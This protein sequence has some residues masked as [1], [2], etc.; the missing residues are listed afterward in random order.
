MKG[1]R[2]CMKWL[3][4]CLIAISMYSKIPV[5]QVEWT[6]EKMSHAMC[7]FPLVGAA[8]G[9]LLGLWLVIAAQFDLSVGIRFLWASAIPFLVTGGIHMDGFMDTMDAVHSYGDRTKKLEI[10]KDPHLGA[11]AV[12]CAAV[13]LLLYTGSMYEFCK[14]AQGKAIFY[15]VLFLFSERVFS[16]LSV[17]MFPSA[18][19][20]GLAATF[21]QASEKKLDKKILI[22]LLVLMA[23]IAF[24]NWG[25]QGL[26][27]YGICLALQGA[28]F[29][30]Y[31]KWSKKNFGGITGDLAGFFLQTEEL[32]CLTAVAFLLKML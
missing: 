20:N 11:F 4:S 14:N 31:D 1:T 16:G 10:L 9:C 27:I 7:F 12:I 29:A 18:K 13:Y 15:P 8:Q 25:I 24:G 3:D 5:P 30:W 22:L 23:A 2:N 6:K 26:K 19:N 32:A 28:L 21:S 17:L